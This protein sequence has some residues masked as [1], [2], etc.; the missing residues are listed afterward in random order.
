[1]GDCMETEVA[2][3]SFTPFVD[4]DVADVNEDDAAA[5]ECCCCCCCCSGS[6]DT[7]DSSPRS[8]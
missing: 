8:S 4:E 5:G 7:I 1:M 2:A 6:G 3:T